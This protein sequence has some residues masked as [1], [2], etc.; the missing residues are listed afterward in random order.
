MEADHT[1]NLYREVHKSVFLLLP[2]R[3][4]MYGE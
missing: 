3:V 4:K 1:L 2:N